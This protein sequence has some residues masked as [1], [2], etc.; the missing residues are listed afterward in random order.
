[1]ALPSLAILPILIGAALLSLTPLDGNAR[2]V[3][4]ISRLTLQWLLGS[5]ALA[6]L[7][8]VLQ[9]S[10]QAFLLQRFGLIALALAMAGAAAS[11]VSASRRSRARCP[12]E[13]VAALALL[14]S[15]VVALTPKIIAARF[16]PFPLVAHN[17]LDP[18]LFGQPALRMLDHGYLELENASHAPGLMTITAVLVQLYDVEPL[19][20]FWMGP[21][22]LYAVFGAGLFLWARAIF[23][24]SIPALLVAAVGPFVLTGNSV[25]Q[26]TPMVLRSNTVL[27]SLL[28]MGLFLTHSLVAND[29]ASK[30]AKA[31]GLVAL[32]ALVVVLF[33]MMNGYRY[34]FL[35]QETRVL[36]TLAAAGGLGL[37]LWAVNRRRWHWDGLFIM[38]LLV[39]CFQFFHAYEGPVYLT[40]IIAYGLALTM[41]RSRIEAIAAVAVVGAAIGFFLMQQQLFTFPSDFSI[42]SS[43]V[44]G[45]TYDAVPVPFAFRISAL[46]EVLSWQVIALLIVGAAGFLVAGSPTGRRAVVV[47]AALMFLVFLLPDNLA[48]RTN[49]AMVPF[50]AVLVAAGADHAGRIAREVVRRLDRDRPVVQK[51][52]PVIIIAAVFPALITP[53]MDFRATIPE[54]QSHNSAIS[55][56]EY[57]LADWLQHN[58]GEN[59]RIVS[60]YQTM[61]ILTSLAN[62]VSL[63]ERHLFPIEMTQRG[64]QQMR[65]IKRSVLSA[66]DSEAAYA[67]IRSLAGTE[68]PRERRYMEAVHLSEGDARYLVVWTMRT[69]L[70]TQQPTI[71]AYLGPTQGAVT[72]QMV[73]PF[74]DPRYFR[75]LAVFGTDAVVFEV[76]PS[77]AF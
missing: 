29:G 28:P 23:R 11:S 59:V 56:I 67:A 3:D 47:V 55:D 72:P 31:E 25:F 77:P 38:F 46:Q 10:G 61:L 14:A 1:M 41:H 58:T 69:W 71:D 40:A 19:A 52:L 34:F 70:W 42:A 63:T 43:L 45:S 62:K 57:E 15:V 21:F 18:L 51:A 75:R 37:L 33:A 12:V 76:L 6:V 73:W 49:R 48:F 66:T 32:Q 65:L 8:V 17:F 26:G 30:R 20:V 2:V 27:L 13:G 4:W 60:D 35:P 5:A 24:R 9:L 16:T 54:G 50:L 7:A 44:F 36:V 22:L 74:T 53:F 39:V 64:R 68:P